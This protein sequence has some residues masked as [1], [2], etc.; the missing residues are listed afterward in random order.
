MSNRAFHDALYAIGNMPIELVRASLAKISVNRDYQPN[1]KFYG[2][3]T[4]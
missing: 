2:A 1:W 4:G 3:V